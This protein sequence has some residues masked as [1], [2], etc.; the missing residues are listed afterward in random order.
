MRLS[1]RGNP[2]HRLLI[3]A[4]MLT[5][6]LIGISPNTANADEASAVEGQTFRIATDTSF[7]PHVVRGEGNEVTGMDIQLMEAIAEDQGFGIEW[8]ALG[9]SAAL[10]AVSSGQADGIIAAAAITD[11]RAQTFDF[12]DPYMDSELAMA[13]REDRVEEFQDWSDLEGETVMAKTGS[14]SVE[15]AE[16]KGAEYGFE[17]R[18]LEQSDPMYQE[19]NLGRAAAVMDDYPVL[20]Y[21]SEQ[22][23]GLT[24]VFDPIPTGEMGFAVAK[25]QNA[26][27]LA[28][29]NDGLANLR[30]SGQYDEIVQEWT[31]GGAA[32]APTGEVDQN[33]KVA[34]QSFQIATDTSFPPHVVR[35]DDNEIT[36]LDIELMQAIAAD[37]GFEIEWQ[38]LGFSPALQSVTSGQ[39]DGII[40]A[41]GIT[42]ERKETFDFSDPY[43]ESQLALAV[44]AGEG[45]Q[46]QDWS[47][48]A[49]QIVM[50]KTGS[51]SLD[52]AQELA[53]E[54]GFEVRA[55]EQSDTMY[56]EVTLG[57]AAAVMDDFTVL[58]YG[59]DQGNGLE[60]VMDPIPV[61]ELGFAV[62]KGQNAE[63]LE[64]FNTGLANLQADGRYDQILANWLGEQTA[65][66][67]RSFLDLLTSSLPIL[68]KG[69]GV[70]LLV[71]AAAIFI[72]SVLG[73]VFGFLK[74]SGITVLRWL[75]DLYVNVFRGTP[76]LVQAF[77]FYFGIP[78]ALKIDIDILVTGIV[79][80]SLNAGA[81]MTEIVRGGIQ[82]VDVGQMEASRSLGLSWMQAMNK[83]IAPQAIKFATPAAINQFIMTLKDTSI[84]A[85]LGLA[86]LTYQGQQIIARNFRSFEMWLIVGALYF[87]VIM[88]LTKLSNVLDRRFNK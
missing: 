76:L 18:T 88:L 69:L 8:Q 33:S 66:E 82:S 67:Q 25:G 32:A 71:T 78:A 50:A 61:G 36:G 16:E 64:A 30:E 57:R 41:A 37:Q 20:A 60:L 40:A 44:R 74:V 3:W 43:L 53:A 1:H 75:A 46:Y 51:L 59:A 56:Q 48:L 12:S 2:L 65:A 85:V 14:L 87:V 9:F 15:L 55:L 63:L 24:T 17:V 11:E 23:N 72:A 80:L 79:V 42:D 13:V 58:A 73:M 31:G 84:L 19:V 10:Q 27:L 38:A 34:G 4:A 86:E 5:L 49:G 52:H 81:Y 47:D 26:E 28:A 70:T 83:V 35:D 22:G 62:A 21:G 77:F 6:A 7:P 54:H 29:F 39:S 45:E 68:L